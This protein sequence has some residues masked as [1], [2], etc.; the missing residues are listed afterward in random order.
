MRTLKIC[1]ATLAFGLASMLP[2]LADTQETYQTVRA[3]TK[4]VSLDLQEQLKGTVHR[5]AGEVIE[6]TGVIQDITTDESPRIQIS[7]GTGHTI[8]VSLDDP[9]L[10]IGDTVHV[11]A[12]I[13][14]TGVVLKALSYYTQDV[15][16]L[17]TV[18][19]PTGTF[20]SSPEPT[21]AVVTHVDG[22]TSGAEQSETTT[23]PATPAKLQE[24]AQTSIAQD[25]AGPV[26]E[27]ATDKSTITPE[28]SVVDAQEAVK[29]VDNKSTTA[30]NTTKKTAQK[31][32]TRKQRLTYATSRAMSASTAR[33]THSASQYASKI[34]QINPQVSPSIAMSIST[35]VVAK[36]RK[37][38]IDP[39]LVL[40]LLAQESRFNPRAVS[41][42][43]AMGLG[44]LMPGTASMLGVRKPFDIAGNIEGTVRYL[45]QMMKKFNGNIAHAL[46]AYNAGPGNVS[47]YRGVPPFKETRNYVRVISTTYQ[48]LVGGLI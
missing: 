29:A 19:L 22:K 26:Q 38:G 4:V 21:V 34:R 23:G 43:G 3:N 5:Q 20:T 13:P 32:T 18:T 27:N 44:Q 2:A 14:T 7:I 31:S 17:D 1:C 9:E 24:V 25:N 39:R 33:E 6:L 10:R 11:L 12:R 37:Y 45:S 40:A 47:R 36:S 42:V 28:K 41:P 16:P 48:K 46:A 8:M 35:N 15:Q 30:K